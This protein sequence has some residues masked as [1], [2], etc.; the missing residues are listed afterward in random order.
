MT[1]NNNENKDACIYNRVF[2]GIC[3]K[4]SLLLRTDSVYDILDKLKNNINLTP[5]LENIFEFARLT[6]FDNI[7]IVIVGQDPYPKAGHAH[8]L[9]FSCLD[10][11]PASLLNIYKCLH[12]HKL[13]NI[14]PTTGNLENWA[15]QG[16][17]LVNTALTTEIGYANAHSKLWEKYTTE[18]FK[19]LSEIKPIVFMLWGNNAKKLKQYLS[20]KSIILEWTHPSPLA[21]SK[22]SFIEC[23]H[24]VEAN[25]IITKLGYDKINWS[26][27]MR[28][29][30]ERHFNCDKN[31]QVVFTDGSCYPNRLC[32]EAKAGYA[33]SFALGS[34][35]DVI[36]YGSIDNTEIF[37]SNQRA[38]GTAI[39]KTLEYLDLRSNE[40]D[41]VII[42][43]DSDFWIKMIEVYMPS[44]VKKNVNFDEKKNADLTK[45][46]WTIYYKLINF[47]M[48]TVQFRHINSHN[49]N[50]WGDFKEGTYEYFC[51]INNDYVDQLAGFARK[52]K[53]NEHRISKAK[54]D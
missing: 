43:S 3:K 13:I 40:W 29:V 39:L 52:L 10:Q 5:K 27:E 34:L 20:P 26:V 16:V 33:A 44:W 48:K 18:L 2:S 24:F 8:G 32:K 31:T 28:S 21:Q 6:E 19:N 1:S 47:D 38:E 37:A 42:V 41:T 50:G 4:W 30:I 25:E 46:L 11:V 7:K 12:K 36:L 15:R 22:Q 9:A 53:N 17:L 45:K 35:K 23:P 54:Y 51:Y 49:K 14:M